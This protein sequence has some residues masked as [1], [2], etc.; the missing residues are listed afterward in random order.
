MVN[1]NAV[2]FMA[3]SFERLLCRFNKMRVRRKR[4]EN[5]RSLRLSASRTT[6]GMTARW[7]FLKPTWKT[8]KDNSVRENLRM[9]EGKK[10]PRLSPG[11]QDLAKLESELQPH[12][13]GAAKGLC[14]SDIKEGCWLPHRS[15]GPTVDCPWSHE[16]PEVS[17][18][19]RVDHLN[20]ILETSAL[21]ELEPLGDCQIQVVKSGREQSVAAYCPGIG[22][23]N[24]F[25]PVHCAGV[26][27]GAVV[28][29][30]GEARSTRGRDDCPGVQRGCRIAD[31]RPVWCGLAITITVSAVGHCERESGLPVSYTAEA[32]ATQNLIQN[33][34]LW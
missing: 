14:L 32:P 16:V 33:P 21:G 3:F 30:I 7:L 15:E 17:G 28:V 6:L 19:E 29:G 25:N 13:H 1:S 10:K 4:E 18:V 24:P 11:P 20:A 27:T 12:S 31:V 8:A 9:C 22:Q 2:L 26:N 23:T 5:T 34:L